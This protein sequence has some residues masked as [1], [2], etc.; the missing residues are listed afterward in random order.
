MTSVI[1]AFR[2]DNISSMGTIA[3]TDCI[4]FRYTEAFNNLGTND[5]T[6]VPTFIF[7][8]SVN[9]YLIIFCS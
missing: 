6:Y 3:N 7:N 5:F 9:L 8:Q 4:V 2:T 1:S